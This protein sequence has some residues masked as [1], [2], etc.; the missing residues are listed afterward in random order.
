MCSVGLSV[1]VMLSSVA[2]VRGKTAPGS[3]RIKDNLYGTKFVS[4]KVGWVVGAFGSIYRTSDGGTSWQ[5]QLSHT[6]E[7]LFDA[8]FVDERQGWIAGRSGVILHTTDGGATWTRQNSGT[9]MHLFSVDFVDAQF[10]CIA[11]DWGTILTTADGG[12]TWQSRTLE[13]DV[14]LNDVSMIDRT[15]GWI[16]GEVGAVLSTEDGGATWTRRETEVSK[17]LF[18]VFFADRQRG[19]LVGIDALIVQTEDG[20][21]TWQ[22]RHGSTE[23][24]ELEQVGFGQAYDNPSLYAI[25]VDGQRGFAVGE[26]GAVFLSD[27]GGRTWTRRVP[28]GKDEP[29]WFRAVSVAPGGG[30]GAIVG[31]KGQRLMIVDGAVTAPSEDTRAAEALH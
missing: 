29:A 15:H 22:V 12:V 18:G 20:G 26:I 4:D 28:P 6:T 1:A 31:A 11:G 30:R 8:D 9:E 16:V 14:I 13:E 5:P 2:A 25:A 19:W 7:Q 3:D 24:R 21:A 23:L 17:T 27:D 10:G